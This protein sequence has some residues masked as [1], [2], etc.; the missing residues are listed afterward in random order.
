[1]I[2]IIFGIII[3]THTFARNN[4]GRFCTFC[5]IFTIVTFCTTGIT[6]YWHWYNP[7]ILFW[8]FSV[9]LSRVCVCV[10]V[11]VKFYG[12]Y[13]LCIQRHSQYT[14]QLDHHMSL[15]LP[16]YNHTQPLFFPPPPS[17]TLSFTPGKSLICLPFLKF[18]RIK[19]VT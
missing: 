13:H 17:P 5:P 9:L 3:D 12:I 7:L 4:I 8:F 1:M 10:C 6:G 14:E 19:N 16:F 2:R 18:C 15:V 11:C